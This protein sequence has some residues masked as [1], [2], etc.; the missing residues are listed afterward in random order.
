MAAK[1]VRIMMFL[2]VGQVLVACSSSNSGVA[3]QVQFNSP[4]DMPS[5]WKQDSSQVPAQQAYLTKT[6]DSFG[7]VF[8]F[9]DTQV[10]LSQFDTAW[11]AQ[12]QERYGSNVRIN[13][14]EVPIATA[15]GADAEMKAD[16]VVAIVGVQ[17][18]W[19]AF[20][21]IVAK[22][23]RDLVSEYSAIEGLHYK[24]FTIDS[25]GHIGGIYHWQDALTAEAFYDAQ[26]HEQISEKY[27]QS[28]S[29]EILSVHSVTAQ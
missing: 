10:A 2:V 20:N 15:G 25:K 26:W 3:V 11:V 13:Y 27:G 23:M 1:I 24:Y 4:T 16:T 29:V 28:A 17:P 9:T 14:F 6:N 7:G 18:P 22:R 21:F 5:E 8:F 12:S 19:Y